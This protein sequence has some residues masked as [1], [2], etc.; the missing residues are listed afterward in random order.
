MMYIVIILIMMISWVHICIKS[1]QIVH[2]KYVDYTPV[3]L[4]EK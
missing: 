1:H 2:S 3:K 4:L